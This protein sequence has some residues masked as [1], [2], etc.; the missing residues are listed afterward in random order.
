MHDALEITI[1]LMWYCICNKSN[2]T[3]CLQDWIR[4]DSADFGVW[5]LDSAGLSLTCLDGPRMALAAL[6][7]LNLGPKV[8]FDAIQHD[9]SRF[10]A[11]TRPRDLWLTRCSKV[12]PGWTQPDSA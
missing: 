4:L 1:R 10:G 6:R 3:T 9:L 11:S 8:G 7:G 12:W 2:P 5:T